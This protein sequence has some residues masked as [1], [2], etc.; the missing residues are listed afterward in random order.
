[1]PRLYIVGASLGWNEKTLVPQVVQKGLVVESVHVPK[2]HRIGIPVE[3]DAQPGCGRLSYLF[4]KVY[5][6]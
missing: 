5:L 3:H 4:L 1:M 6:G 2:S